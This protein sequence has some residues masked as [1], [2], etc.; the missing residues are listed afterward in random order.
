MSLG[1]VGGDGGV[2]DANGGLDGIC[3]SENI[4]MEER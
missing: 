1:G 4:E 3:K 2:S